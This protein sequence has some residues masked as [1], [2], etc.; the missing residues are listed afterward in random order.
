M[1]DQVGNMVD[2]LGN[3]GDWL[4]NMGVEV[5]DRVRNIWSIHI[6]L[7]LMALNVDAN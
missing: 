2:L 1:E 5:R 6:F 3:L 4:E 7:L